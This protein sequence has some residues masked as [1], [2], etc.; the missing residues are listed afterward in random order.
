MRIINILG[1]HIAKSLQDRIGLEDLLFNAGFLR[2]IACIFIE[3]NGAMRFW[4][5][6]KHG[7]RKRSKQSWNPLEVCEVPEQP[8]L[9]IHD[10]VLFCHQVIGAERRRK[11]SAKLHED[12]L[13]SL[14]L[15]SPTLTRNYDGPK[16]HW[17]CLVGRH[18]PVI[19]TC[20][21]RGLSQPSDWFRASFSMAAYEAAATEN[22]WGGRF[23]SSPLPG[24]TMGGGGGGLALV[25][26]PGLSARTT[27][28][29]NC[30]FSL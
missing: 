17:H 29:R 26:A 30:A 21:D 15:S 20:R 8:E 13:R 23:A 6:K 10:W 14:R 12:L 19:S 22:K 5:S 18:V 11:N 1:F 4:T 24:K 25:Q 27:D 2:L 16:A 3:Q 9:W 7:W 28:V